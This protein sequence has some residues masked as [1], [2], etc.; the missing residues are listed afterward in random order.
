MTP[1]AANPVTPSAPQTGPG[2]PAA[3]QTPQSE[4]PCGAWYGKKLLLLI[5]LAFL[6]HLGLI[7]F[8]G[9]K[10]QIVPRRVSHVP[11]LQLAS[12]GNP[13]IALEDPT[14]FALPN[15]KDFSSV[16]WAK[17]PVASEPSFQWIESPRWLAPETNRPAAT[18]GQFAPAPRR[19]EMVEEV[20]PPPA[21]AG[22]PAQMGGAMPISSSLIILGGSG[23][24]QFAQHD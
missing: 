20:K 2:P 12:D 10:T 7:W 13:V 14:L 19:L 23:R 11:R 17:V 22:T 5:A 24:P 16:S 15:R 21:M 18:F 6:V 8:F 1:P 3:S 9:A 4:L